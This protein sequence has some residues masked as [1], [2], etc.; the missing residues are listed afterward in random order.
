MKNITLLLLS[1][2]TEYWQINIESEFIN[3]INPAV[4]LLA[5]ILSPNQ[6]STIYKNNI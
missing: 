1:Y 2:F 6:A 4:A 3:V 5:A